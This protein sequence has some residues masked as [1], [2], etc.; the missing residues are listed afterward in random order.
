MEV[1]IMLPNT[2]LSKDG[3]SY[4]IFRGIA[5]TGGWNILQND[6][7]CRCTL[8]LPTFIV[9]FR[10]SNIRGLILGLR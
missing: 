9:L 6:A 3:L 5:Y 7:A 4:R 10:L 8:L 1:V 2:Q